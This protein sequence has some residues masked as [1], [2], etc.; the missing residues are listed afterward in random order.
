MVIV[1]ADLEIRIQVQ[2]GYLGVDSRKQGSEGRQGRKG[3]EC[4]E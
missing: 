4:K 1:L 2:I 3:S